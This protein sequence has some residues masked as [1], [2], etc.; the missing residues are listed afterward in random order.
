MTTNK[1]ISYLEQNEFNIDSLKSLLNVDEN[2][3]KNLNFNRKLNKDLIVWNVI[4]REIEFEINQFLLAYQDQENYSNYE[5][6]IL[7]WKNEIQVAIIYENAFK[8]N[9][10]ILR[11][12]NDG[13]KRFLDKYNSRYGVNLKSKD[14]RKNYF[15]LYEFGT[16]CYSDGSPTDKFFE[17]MRLVHNKKDKKLKSWLFSLN[18]NLRLFGAIGLQWMEKEGRKLTSSEI[19]MINE[20]R[21]RNHIINSCSGCISGQSTLNSLLEDEYLDS[22]YKSYKKIGWFK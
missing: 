17:M 14:F 8:R 6:S 9:K 19:L 5:I 18:I 4:E 7:Y 3:V 16:A 20:L 1:I 13:F 2:L 21:S 22:F 12:T 11:K 10:T 15:S